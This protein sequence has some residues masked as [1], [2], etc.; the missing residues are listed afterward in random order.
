MSDLW[1]MDRKEGPWGNGG[2]ES[3][4]SHAMV[5]MIDFMRPKMY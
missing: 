3:R 5:C 4:I 1:G 2:K